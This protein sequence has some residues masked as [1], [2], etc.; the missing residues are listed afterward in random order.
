MRLAL[1]LVAVSLVPAEVT[2]QAGAPPPPAASEH[3]LSPE[4][5]EAVL[6]EA[7]RKREA[8][9]ARLDP[10]AAEQTLRPPVQGEVGFSIGTGGYREVFGTGIYPMG[11]DG[12]AV[13][14]LDF[15]DLGKR[16]FR[17]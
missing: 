2:A 1:T 5:I 3:R 4:Q 16:R 11:N 17:R 12:V 15:V 9:G 8:T 13:I 6:A 10:E 14:S 7:A